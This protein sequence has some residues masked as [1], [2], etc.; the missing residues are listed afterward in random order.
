MTE[1]KRNNQTG[2]SGEKAD[3]LVPVI[4]SENQKGGYPAVIKNNYSRP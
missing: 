4:L 2:H 1:S 3:F